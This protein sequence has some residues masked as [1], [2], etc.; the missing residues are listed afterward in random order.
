MYSYLRSFYYVG[1][2]YECPFC[3]GHFRKLLPAGLNNKVLKDV[4][5]GGYRLNAQCPRCNSGDRERLIY[6]Y[7]KNKTDLLFTNNNI[8]LLHVAPEKNLQK[9]LSLKSNIDYISA[10]LKSPSVMVKMDIT[11][12]KYEDNYFDVIICNHVLEHI[13]DD[14]RAMSE[15]YRVLKPNGWA[16]LQVPISVSLKK[17]P[18][19]IQRLQHL[20]KGKRCLDKVTMSESML[21]ITKIDLKMLDFTL[22][23]IT[24]QMI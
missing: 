10:D 8:R 14:H 21:K 16:I 17:K 5:G 6:W 7:I 4:V 19:K 18:T 3:S 12:I 1:S 15:L 24:L 9:V 13:P 2:R 22:M 23:Y 11:N 20:K